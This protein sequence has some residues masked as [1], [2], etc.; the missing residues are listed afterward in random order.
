MLEDI[1]INTKQPMV[2]ISNLINKNDFRK[3]KNKFGL[4]EITLYHNIEMVK[5]NS[6]KKIEK[7]L[8]NEM[9]EDISINTKQ[10]MAKNNSGK[11]IEKKLKNEMLE[12]ISINTKQP[13]VKNNSGKKIEKN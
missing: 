5:N 1:S 8:K 13:M 2:E 9:L 6:G 11:K 10:P 7:K 12:D 3:I 4:K